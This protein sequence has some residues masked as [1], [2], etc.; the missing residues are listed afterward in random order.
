MRFDIDRLSR[1]AGI[2]DSKGSLNEASNRSLHDDKSVADEVAWRWG[3]N[4]LSEAD[5]ELTEREL[6]ELDEIMG[7]DPEIEEWGG[8]AGDEHDPGDDARGALAGDEDYINEIPGEPLRA[9]EDAA[10]DEGVPGRVGEL[11][12]IQ[13]NEQDDLEPSDHEDL[14]E[15]TFL[16]IDEEMIREELLRMRSEKL[17]ENQLRGAIRNEI[18][19]IFHDLGVEQDHSWV[20]GDNQPINSREGLVN[21]AFPGIGFR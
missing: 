10:D 1:L 3:K 8:R 15:D 6:D 9:Y 12:N 5:D 17:Q 7:D 4:Q 19:S 11:D 2:A 21:L 18:Q 14:E 13:W 16:E 20:Y